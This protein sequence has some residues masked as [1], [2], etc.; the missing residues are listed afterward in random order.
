MVARSQVIFFFECNKSLSQDAWKSFDYTYKN[1][2]A[3]WSVTFSQY[4]KPV[5]WRTSE[6]SLKL[7]KE[8]LATK[9]GRFLFFGLDRSVCLTVLFIWVSD[10]SVLWT[11]PFDLAENHSVHSMTG[12]KTVIDDRSMAV[13]LL[14]EWIGTL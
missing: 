2:F 12:T 10:R 6:Y 14:K 1:G 8:L 4:L 11:I 13:C 9:H 5:L 3:L 7:L